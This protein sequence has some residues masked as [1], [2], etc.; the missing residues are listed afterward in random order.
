MYK[1]NKIR[2]KE[3]GIESIETGGRNGKN[4]TCVVRSGS[5]AGSHGKMWDSA[6]LFDNLTWLTANEAA[7]YLRLPSVGA[8]RVLVCKR[9]VPFHKLGRRLRFKKV[10]LDQLLETSRNGGLH[11]NI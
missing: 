9:D 6:V 1:G 7:Q 11:G 5:K 4:G 8:L 3:K 2:K 10:E